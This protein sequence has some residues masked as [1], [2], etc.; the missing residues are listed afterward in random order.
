[1]HSNKIVLAAMCLAS[2]IYAKRDYLPPLHLENIVSEP[3][4][5]FLEN[6]QN[7]NIANNHSIAQDLDLRIYQ[8]GN[9]VAYSISIDNSF[10]VV[11][12]T[13]TSNADLTIEILRYANSG[14]DNVILGYS[15]W[16][17]N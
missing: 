16:E 10:E 9:L 12:F 14:S 15:F 4:Q 8:N 11:D 7:S 2:I 17:D 3:V 5:R 13:T 1:M 6:N